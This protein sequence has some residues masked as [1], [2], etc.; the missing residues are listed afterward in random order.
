MVWLICF[1]SLKKKNSDILIYNTHT[2]GPTE[3]ASHT[4]TISR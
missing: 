4:K 1:E 2:I 3:L